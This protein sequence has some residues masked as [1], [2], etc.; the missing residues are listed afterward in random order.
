MLCEIAD[1]DVLATVLTTNV[2]DTAFSLRRGKIGE[3][4][5]LLLQTW[6]PLALIANGQ[7][8]RKLIPMETK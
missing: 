7:F 4:H 1:L 6:S 3:F 8:L 2:H 5:Y